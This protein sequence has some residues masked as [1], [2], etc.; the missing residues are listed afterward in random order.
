MKMGAHYSGGQVGTIN[1]LA[2]RFA[3]IYQLEK[4]NQLNQDSTYSI[5]EK[6]IKKFYS[7]KY[8]I[9][10]PK[11]LVIT[12]GKQVIDISRLALRCLYDRVPGVG[13][14]KEKSSSGNDFSVLR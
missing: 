9:A 2:G 1:Q 6:I 10:N 4:Q 8:F 14:F 3:Y 5:H 7:Y 12:E 13:I 11:M